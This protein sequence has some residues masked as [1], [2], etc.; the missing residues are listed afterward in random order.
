MLGK[1]SQYTG[2]ITNFHRHGN[3]TDR[4]RQIHPVVQIHWDTTN[5]L[6]VITISACTEN[7]ILFISD[8]KCSI[9]TLL[10]FINGLIFSIYYKLGESKLMVLTNSVDN[11]FLKLTLFK[12]KSDK[13]TLLGSGV[14]RESV[15]QT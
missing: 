10:Q 14:A 11:T 9:S 15:N 12:N 8:R 5:D 1:H 3:S 7:V 13:L 4:E 6:M 2:P